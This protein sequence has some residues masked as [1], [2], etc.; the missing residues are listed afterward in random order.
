MTQPQDK[1]KSPLLTAKLYDLLKFIALVL[2]PA[3]GSAYFALSDIWGL[4][5]GK[6][7]VGSITVLDTFL[8]GLLHI[9]NQ[10]YK[11]SDAPY[12]GTVHVTDDGSKKTFNLSLNGDPNTLDQQDSV[13][14]KV[15]TTPPVDPNPVGP[16]ATD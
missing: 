4:P 2:L 15:V 9:S 10:N 1:N 13:N 6:Q 3:L 16:P 5:D 14:F 11:N 7:I 8:G 12:D